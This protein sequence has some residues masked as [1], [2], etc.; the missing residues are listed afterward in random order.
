VWIFSGK[1]KEIAVLNNNT[2]TKTTPTTINALL[3]PL[4]F[5]SSL[6][7]IHVLQQLSGLPIVAE[8]KF[9]MQMDVKSL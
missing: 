2:T 4:P 8:S 1:Y 7:N 5:I 9:W 3:I 6:L